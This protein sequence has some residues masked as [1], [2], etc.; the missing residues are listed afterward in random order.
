[1]G[2]HHSEKQQS[3][4]QTLITG[5]NVTCRP[6]INPDENRSRDGGVALRAFKEMATI[7]LGNLKTEN[8]ESPV[9]EILNAFKLM[10]RRSLTRASRAPV[11]WLAADGH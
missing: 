1:M 2:K 4:R 5:I 3:L 11:Y 9:E 6:L 8:Y 7:F 10:R